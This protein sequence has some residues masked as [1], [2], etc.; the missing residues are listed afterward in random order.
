VP[1]GNDPA[2]SLA[3]LD[4]PQ[5]SV[6]LSLSRMTRKPRRMA[7]P[8]IATQTKG[9]L[10]ASVMGARMPVSYPLV[11]APNS[12]PRPKNNTS[13]ASAPS[14]LMIR[15]VV[16]TSPTS[17]GRTVRPVQP[18]RAIRFLPLPRHM[19]RTPGQSRLARPADR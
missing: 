8:I 11:L 14:A 15:I 17:R 3:G 12:R 16:L 4:Q 5:L 1:E 9:H 18:P 13:I 19:E 6:S 7:K 10:I 2:Q